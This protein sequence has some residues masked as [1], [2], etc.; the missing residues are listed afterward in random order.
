M[1]EVAAIVL[2]AGLGTR[3]GGAKLLAEFRGKPL[4]RH[5]VEAA[6][7]SRAA[8]V[9]VVVGHEAGRVRA[10]L[11]GLPLAF[12]DNPGFAEGLSTSLQAGFAALPAEAGGAVILLADMPRVSAGLIDAICSAWLEGRPDAVV[13]SFR[14]RRGNPVLL[15]RG[16]APEIA[17]LRGDTGA[18]PLLKGR[19]GVRDLAVDDEA[20]LLDADTPEALSHLD[21]FT[22]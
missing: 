15:S 2:A 22:S 12:V 6:L 20:V 4:V 17:R 18:S 3:F 9:I 7:A 11:Q 21:P 16:L 14:G 13:P 1:S 10:A 5:A 8:P 19:P